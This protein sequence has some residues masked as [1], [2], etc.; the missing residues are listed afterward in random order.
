MVNFRKQ[1]PGM[2]CAPGDAVLKNKQRKNK[3]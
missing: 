2:Y 1:L 3:K